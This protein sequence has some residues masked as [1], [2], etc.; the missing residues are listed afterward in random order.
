MP[1]QFNVTECRRLIWRHAIQASAAA[2]ASAAVPLPLGAAMG[3]AGFDLVKPIQKHL[4]GVLCDRAGIDSAWISNKLERQCSTPAQRRALSQMARKLT[5]QG[6]ARAE[7]AG[8][9]RLLGRSTGKAVPLAAATIAGVIAARDTWQLGMRCL[10]LAQVGR[11]RS[12]ESRV[13]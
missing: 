6:F 9:A 13:R 1:T 2:A 3:M 4:V 11:R 12:E 7:R 8:I 5:E 10:E